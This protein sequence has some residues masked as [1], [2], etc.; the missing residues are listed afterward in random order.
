MLVWYLRL[1]GVTLSGGRVPL[2]GAEIGERTY[3]APHSVIMK[4]ERL[5][6]GLLYAGGLRL[7]SLGTRQPK[8]MRTKQETG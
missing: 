2:Y 3:V 5:L 6:P 1:I 7:R 8:A 4:G